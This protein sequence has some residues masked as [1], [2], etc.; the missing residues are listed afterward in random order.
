MSTLDTTISMIQLLSDSE[1]DAIQSIARAFLSKTDRSNVYTPQTEEQ[2]LARIDS[3]MLH[4][5]QGL[6]ED[7]AK[8]ES[9]IIAE[10]GL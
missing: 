10:F 5:E 1:L 4:G 7:A 3:S 8:V 2:L 9:D 6:Y